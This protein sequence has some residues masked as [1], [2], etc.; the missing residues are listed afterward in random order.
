ML[1]LIGGTS[2]GKSTLAKYLK[3]T[4][5][6][7]QILELTTR[8]PRPGEKNGTDY[9]FTEGYSFTRQLENNELVGALS[10][11]RYQNGEC[12]TVQY[13]T[14]KDHI[15]K[16]GDKA[17]LVTNAGAAKL[18]KQYNEEHDN[19]YKLFIVYV[20]V[21]VDEQARR[22]KARGDEPEEIKKRIASDAEALADVTTYADYTVDNSSSSVGCIGTEIASMYEQ[23][24][25]DLEGTHGNI[26]NNS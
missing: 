7:E 9:W 13:G 22:L 1:I 23:Y 2:S 24:L 20:K 26:H 16:A 17:V 21:D 11:N 18:I 15:A 3:Q 10:F 5:R 19:V 25:K 8:I 14:R 6:Y 12:V 4:E